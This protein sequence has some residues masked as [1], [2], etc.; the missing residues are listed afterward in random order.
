MANSFH[1]ETQQTADIPP[2]PDPEHDANKDTWE[3]LEADEWVWEH[4]QCL[5]ADWTME[6]NYSGRRFHQEWARTKIIEVAYK[7]DGDVNIRDVKYS[8]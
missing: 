4:S 1:E 8:T 7:G 5:R 6:T 2:D 3:V